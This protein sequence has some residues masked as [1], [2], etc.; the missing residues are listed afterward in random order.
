M[1]IAMHH[2]GND[3][4]RLEIGG[5]L[6]RVDLRRCEVELAD[7]LARLGSIKLLCVLTEFE[8]WDQQFDWDNLTFYLKHGDA[9]ARIAIVGD[10]HWRSPALI[11]AIADL[12]RAP[13]EFF[14]IDRLADARAWLAA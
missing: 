8:G 4:Y 7:E 1:P 12:R 9:I 2:E 13:V 3:T 6:R 14:T 10:E 5:V 11:F